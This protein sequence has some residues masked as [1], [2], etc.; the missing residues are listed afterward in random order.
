MATVATILH[1]TRLVLDPPGYRLRQVNTPFIEPENRFG[2]IVTEQ[3]RHAPALRGARRPVEDQLVDALPTLDSDQ[4]SRLSARIRRFVWS[5]GD[6]IVR[7]GDRTDR[8][9]VIAEGEVE[10]LRTEPGRASHLVARLVAA[11]TS[12]RSACST[13]FAGRPPC[14]R[15]HASSRS[16][17]SAMPS[18]SW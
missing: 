17:L 6:E 9:Y 16:P 13:V 18:W 7:Q 12:V 4:R 14:G 1:T 15:S 10:V 11:T 8:F 5:V 3:R 2:A